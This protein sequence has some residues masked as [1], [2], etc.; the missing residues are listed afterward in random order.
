M[1]KDLKKSENILPDGNP[2]I[3]DDLLL[4]DSFPV[5]GP[6]NSKFA[7]YWGIKNYNQ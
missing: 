6:A 1:I 4:T 5:G 2:L 3:V 7:L